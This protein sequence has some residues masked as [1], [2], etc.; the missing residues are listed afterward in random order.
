VFDKAPRI[1]YN[2]ASSSSSVDADKPIDR[3]VYVRYNQAF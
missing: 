1:S 3:F 2:G